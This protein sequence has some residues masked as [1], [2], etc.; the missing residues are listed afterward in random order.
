M[1][2]VKQI[3]NEELHL[4]LNEVDV[5]NFPSFGEHLPSISE[6]DD[7]INQELIATVLKEIKDFIKKHKK[8]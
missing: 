4:F 1:P 5:A 2:S 8:K 7:E 3:I 6:E